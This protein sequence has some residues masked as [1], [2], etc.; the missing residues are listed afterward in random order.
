MR[1]SDKKWGS[2]RIFIKKQCFQ[3]KLSR[4]VKLPVYWMKGITFWKI[5]RRVNSFRIDSILWENFVDMWNEMF[6]FWPF[7]L[8]FGWFFH[9]RISNAIFSYV[10]SFTN[11]KLVSNV[12]RMHL[13]VRLVSVS[14]FFGNV[15][16]GI[17][18]IARNLLLSN[19]NWQIL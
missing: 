11:K 7:S 8:F 13:W 15:D 9:V 4:V 1:W 10:R 14:F 17:D 5:I 18:C 3:T 16:D 12:P 6:S 2:V 19:Y